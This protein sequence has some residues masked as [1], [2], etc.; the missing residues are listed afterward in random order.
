MVSE[1]YKELLATTASICTVLQFL[2][3][4]LV[5]K[6]Y[7]INGTT[8]DTSGF[9][10]VACL[11]SCSFWL[12]YGQLIGD[13]F[14]IWVNITGT[15]LQ[16]SYIAVYT[17]YCTQKSLILKQF[18]T[19]VIFITVVYFYSIINQDKAEVTSQI[20][21][22]SCA[23]TILF[24]AS[25]LTMLAHVIREKNADSLPFPVIIAS[26]V[27][28]CQWFAYGILLNDPFIQMPN[29]LGCILSAFQLSLFTIYPAKKLIDSH[30]I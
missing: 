8:G 2:A 14:V 20:G 16:L 4:I 29:F 1:S 30:I 22:L 27:V 3:G 28:S 9:S 5:C 15:F 12:R 26:F 19:S 11:L 23:L 17:K 6:K 21:L 18:I 24:F 10:F 25:P 7:I 13:S